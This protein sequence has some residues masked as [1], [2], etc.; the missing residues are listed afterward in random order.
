MRGIVEHWVSA[1]RGYEDDVWLILRN[2]FSFNGLGVLV[3]EATVVKVRRGS[4]CCYSI[5]W[6]LDPA[7]YSML[8]VGYRYL[9]ELRPSMCDFFRLVKC[10]LIY[11]AD[12]LAEHIQAM[13]EANVEHDDVES[14]VGVSLPKVSKAEDV[15]SDLSVFARGSALEQ[16]VYFGRFIEK[17]RRSETSSQSSDNGNGSDRETVLSITSR[18]GVSVEQRAV[19]SDVVERGR[20]VTKS[21]LLGLGERSVNRRSMG[22]AKR[23]K[24]VCGRENGELDENDAEGGDIPDD[25]SI[26]G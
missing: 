18:Q 12:D 9:A 21:Q 2:G 8:G 16:K 20:V 13:R 24:S 1:V 7:C 25:V 17:R 14:I 11:N 15:N 19:A 4:S 22:P 26:A 23:I 3:K 10:E 6:V 5:C